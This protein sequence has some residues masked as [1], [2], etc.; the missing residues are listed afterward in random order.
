MNSLKKRE[1]EEFNDLIK[2]IQ[3]E[4]D[5]EELSIFSKKVIEEFRHPKNWGKINDA[6]AQSVITGPCGDT[7]SIF[8]KIENNIITKSS[9]LTDGCGPTVACGSKLTTLIKNK[10]INEIE[11]ITS[12]EILEALDGLPPENQHCALLVVNTFH[13]ALD[14]FKNGL[15]VNEFMLNSKKY[16]ELEK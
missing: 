11:K 1:I 8:L 9:F 14:D 13:K 12:E 2:K 5:Q 3:E 16:P 7:V 15:K 4:V 6:N 10:S